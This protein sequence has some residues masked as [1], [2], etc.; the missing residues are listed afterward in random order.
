MAYERERQVALEAA[1]A[2]SLLVERVR[3]ELGPVAIEKEDRSPVTVADFGSQALVCRAL[4]EAFPDDDVVGEETATELRKPAMAAHLEQVTGYVRALVPGATSGAVADWIDHG[5]GDVGSRFWTLDPIDGTKGF[6]R[7]DQYA[8]ALALIEGGEVQLGLLACPAL[9]IADADDSPRGVLFVAQRGQGA[10]MQPL[11][12]G[13]ARPITVAAG[14]DVGN[15]RLTES[16]EASHSNHSRQ[17]L[18]A[19]AVGLS[20]PSL[21]MDS[22]A[23]YGAIASGRAAL[24]LRLPSPRAPDYHEKI[25]DHAAGAIVVEEAGGRVTDMH[26]RRLDFA[27]A[28]LLAH[29]AGVVVSNGSIHEAVLD[30]LRRTG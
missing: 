7:G 12:G 18:V 16:V 11:A 25:W 20:A 10:S 23:K 30:A 17:A 2:A 9:P 14:D 3:R 5:A 27:S 1:Q 21:R 22:Q 28:R 8:V 24:Y 19:R 4:A 6:L 26:G 29:P 15:M 13:E